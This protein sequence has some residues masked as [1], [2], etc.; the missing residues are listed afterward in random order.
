MLVIEKGK[1]LHSF[2]S[3]RTLANIPE[4]KDKELG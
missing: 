1:G 3:H 2:L 4:L